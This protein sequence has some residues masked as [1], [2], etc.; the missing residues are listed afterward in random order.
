MSNPGGATISAEQLKARYVGTGHADM[1]KYEFVTN[2]HRDTYASHVSHYDQLSY[3]AVAQN[4]SVGRARLQFL[5]KMI[6][7]CGPPPPSKNVDAMDEK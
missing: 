7:P 2:Q 6:R 3:Y 4:E 5:E 1:S